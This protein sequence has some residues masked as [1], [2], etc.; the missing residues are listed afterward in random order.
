MCNTSDELNHRIINYHITELFYPT[1]RLFDRN[2]NMFIL[3]PLDNISIYRDNTYNI[4]YIIIVTLSDTEFLTNMTHHRDLTIYN[5]T[6][7]CRPLYPI[8]KLYV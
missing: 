8:S 6:R 7:L 3:L 1:G 2:I 4:H 5:P